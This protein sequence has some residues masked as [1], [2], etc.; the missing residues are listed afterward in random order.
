MIEVV[1]IVRRSV[2]V[3][4]D[5]F[6]VEKET[7][8]VRSVT[9]LLCE[10]VVPSV[11]V[12]LAEQLSATDSVEVTCFVST[13][14]VTVLLE[15]SAALLERVWEMV[16]AT[17]VDKLL[18]RDDDGEAVLLALRSTVAV[19]DGVV[20]TVVLRFVVN[21]GD[22]ELLLVTDDVAEAL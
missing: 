6:E 10:L 18:D 2:T 12:E 7:V 16:H 8:H 15:L 17:V 14:R 13:L 19:R 20:V 9:F 1:L 21:V 5:V 11:G 3:D 4:D 22:I